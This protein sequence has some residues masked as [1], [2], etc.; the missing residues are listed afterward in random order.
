MLDTDVLRRVVVRVDLVATLPATEPLLLGPVPAF[1]VAALRTALGR[2]RRVHLLRPNFELGGLVFDV[3]VEPSERPR[4]ERF[5][6]RHS[7]SYIG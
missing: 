7:V 2:V 3:L 4:V 5:R 6:A 1:G